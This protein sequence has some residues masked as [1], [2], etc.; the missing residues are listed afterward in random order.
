M[1]TGGSINFLPQW[2]G[3]SLLLESEWTQ[4]P[5]VHLY[6]DASD[7]YRLWSLLGWRLVQLHMVTS[8]GY[9]LPPSTESSCLPLW[10]HVPPGEFTGPGS[11]YC[12]TDNATVCRDLAEMTLPIPNAHGL[13]AYLILLSSYWKLSCPHPRLFQPHCRLPLPFLYAGR[14]LSQASCRPP[15]TIPC[16]PPN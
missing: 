12:S 13:S 4:A 9:L 7:R 11:E 10:S 6:T 14:S 5:H 1:L 3:S 2:L 8:A 16:L 15:T